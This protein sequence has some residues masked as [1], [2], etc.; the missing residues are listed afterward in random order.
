MSSSGRAKL[1]FLLCGPEEEEEGTA[2]S[3][4]SSSLIISPSPT[5]SS[6]S[7]RPLSKPDSPSKSAPESLSH[8]EL[9]TSAAASSHDLVDPVEGRSPRVPQKLPSISLHIGA[10]SYSSKTNGSTNPAAWQ[11]N[12][13]DLPPL[14]PSAFRTGEASATVPFFHQNGF[15]FPYQLPN[16]VMPVRRPPPYPLYNPSDQLHRMGRPFLAPSPSP[17]LKRP[18]HPHSH[19]DFAHHGSPLNAFPSVVHGQGQS[20]S[21]LANGGSSK[22]CHN[23]GARDTPSWRKDPATGDTLC[24]AC[25]LYLRLH[26]RR[27]IFRKLQDG[28]TRAYHPVHL[29]HL[30]EIPPEG[31][32]LNFLDVKSSIS[33]TCSNCLAEKT[34]VWRRSA[35]GDR[36]LCNACALTER[37]QKR[38]RVAE[39]SPGDEPSP[40]DTDMSSHQ[41][42]DKAAASSIN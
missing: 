31:G 10:S 5:P 4:K 34:P 13:L 22:T 14:P 11:P 38:P 3:L 26:N 27:R 9:L 25:G 12:P 20:A 39:D 19:G 7:A 30:T 29:S 24:N 8:M 36:L 15:K 28:R 18:I 1:S 32:E 35:C 33:R 21:N 2:T 16:Y 6:S 41:T 23:C 17:S 37:T 40:S 42:L